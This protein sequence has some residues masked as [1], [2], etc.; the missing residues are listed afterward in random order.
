MT[1]K[2]EWKYKYV[3]ING[4]GFIMILM[5]GTSGILRDWF[6]WYPFGLIT[7]PFMRAILETLEKK[8]EN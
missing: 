1:T 8:G 4:F 5:G 2:K 3:A 6:F 7:V